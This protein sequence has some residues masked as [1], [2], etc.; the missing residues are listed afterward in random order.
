MRE[1]AKA[2]KLNFYEPSSSN[3][4][5]DPHNKSLEVAVDDGP[6]IIFPGQVPK[7]AGNSTQ[8]K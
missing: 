1:S 5:E 2:Q 8:N 7:S 4:N 6:E 3:D